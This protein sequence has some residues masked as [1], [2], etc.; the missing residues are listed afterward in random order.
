MRRGFFFEPMTFAVAI[1]LFLV[2]RELA[3]IQSNTKNQAIALYRIAEALE[4]MKDPKG[5]HPSDPME[6]GR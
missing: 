3:S 2:W 1:L 4:R 5:P 6:A